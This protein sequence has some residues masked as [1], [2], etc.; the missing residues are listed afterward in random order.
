V[1]TLL[2]WAKGGECRTSEDS[3]AHFIA[4]HEILNFGWEAVIDRSMNGSCTSEPTDVGLADPQACWTERRMRLCLDTQPFESTESHHNCCPTPFGFAGAPSLI[5][6]CTARLAISQMPSRWQGVNCEPDRTQ[7]AVP[8]PGLI[9]TTKDMTDLID[10]DG[11]RWSSA[12]QTPPTDHTRQN[13][14]PLE[15]RGANIT[16]RWHACL[17]PCMDAWHGWH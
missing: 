15:T 11:F 1:Q 17:D 7:N 10:H 3:A 16:Q 6:C 5:T 13:R 8:P 9:G 14:R 4:A 2:G 12:A